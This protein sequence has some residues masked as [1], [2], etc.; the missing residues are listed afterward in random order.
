MSR[1]EDRIKD[2]A[3]ALG[4]ELVGIAPATEADG[5]ERAEP[6]PAFIEYERA[7]TPVTTKRSKYAEKGIPDDYSPGSCR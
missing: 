1:L 4:F 2:Q 6:S 7:C 5:L 3:R